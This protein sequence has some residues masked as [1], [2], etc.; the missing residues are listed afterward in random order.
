[1]EIPIIFTQKIGASHDLG[2]RENVDIRRANAANLGATDPRRC[3]GWSAMVLQ[4]CSEKVFRMTMDDN[5]K[6]HLDFF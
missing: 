4:R 3:H 2:P 5:H 6:N 1:M